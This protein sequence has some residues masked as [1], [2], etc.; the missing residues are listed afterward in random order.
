MKTGVC[1]VCG[2]IV[3]SGARG[4]LRSFCHGCARERHLA[5][6]REINRKRRE[7]LRAGKTSDR[8]DR[9]SDNNDSGRLQGQEL[10][11]SGGVVNDGSRW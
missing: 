8:I 11:G 10:S 3:R 1:V 7:V 5:S 2:V 4:P 9:E 6:M